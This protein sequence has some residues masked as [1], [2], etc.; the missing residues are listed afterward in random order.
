MCM[1]WS[2]QSTISISFRNT[3]ELWIKTGQMAQ[4]EDKRRYI[5]IHEICKTLSPTLIQ[6]LPT[7]HVLTG[8]NTTAALYGK[9][10]IT[11]YNVVQKNP[12]KFI[13][14]LSLGNND[15]SAARNLM[16]AHHDP[17]GKGEKG[18]CHL[19]KLRNRLA[20][21]DS[22]IAQLPPCEVSFVEK[23]KRAMYQTKISMSAHIAKLQII[24]P[25]QHEQQIKNIPV[26]G[27]LC[28]VL[29]QGPMASELLDSLVCACAGQTFCCRKCICKEHNLRYTEPCLYYCSDGC[30][31]P[32]TRKD[33]YDDNTDVVDDDNLNNE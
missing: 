7:M 22:S 17:L 5:P 21:Y 32:Y 30:H 12:E 13:S 16:E 26:G 29:F 15:I 24:S 31:N 28:P 27:Y 20:G 1:F 11:C 2:L 19:N 14:L 23:C 3:S 18:T 33:T 25:L 8:C 4:V 10:K 6:I 9:G